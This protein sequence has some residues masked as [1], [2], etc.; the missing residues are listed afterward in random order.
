MARLG[1]GTANGSCSLLHAA[2]LGYGASL[3]LDLPVVVTLLDKKSRRELDDP[4]DLLGAV[5]E[6]WTIAGHQLPAG[7]LHWSVK[8]EIPP[9]QGLKSSAAVSIAALRALCQATEKTLPNSDLVDLAADSQI[10]AGVSITGSVDDAWAAAEGGWKLVNSSLPAAEGVLL[11]SPGPAAEDWDIL[12]IL[13]G[14]RKER[15]DPDTFAWHQ[16]GFQQALEALE[17]GDALMAMTWNGRS[18]VSVLNDMNGRQLTND[19]FLS[20]A[21]AAGISGSGP[22]IVIFS[23]AVSKP[24]LDRLKQWYSSRQRDVEVLEVKIINQVIVENEEDE[25]GN[26]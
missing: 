16:Q 2:G 15:P 18:M 5:L 9:R 3:A 12:L 20:G 19:A 10:R 26:D 22:A 23:P 7:E 8:S 17:K 11:E 13:R 14:D 6:S 24:T 4:D 1:K 25:Q 21:R